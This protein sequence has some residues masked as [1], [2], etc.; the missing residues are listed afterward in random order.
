MVM[1]GLVLLIR[2]L[3]VGF[4]MDAI[5]RMEVSGRGG[6]HEQESF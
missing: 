5:C 4:R 2:L 6:Y 1:G 3:L